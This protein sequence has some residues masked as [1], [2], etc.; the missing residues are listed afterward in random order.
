MIDRFSLSR[1]AFGAGLAGLGL[2]SMLPR[3]V[4]AQET[5]SVTT[6]L[7]T[8]D[9]PAD[10]QRVVCIDSRLDLEPAVALGLNVIG[11]AYGE[12][13]PW[14]PAQP[15]WA[16]VG[17]IPDL[18]QVLAL[19]PDLII[20]TDVGDHDSEY[21]PINRL[22]DVAPVLP[23][24]YTQ[25]WKEI[26]A[27]IGAWTG[28]DGAA[29]TVLA[30]Y[31]ALI[32]D[33]KL[34]RA[35]QIGSKTIAVVQ[36]WSDGTVFLQAEMSLLQ[37]QVMADLGS[38]TIPPVEGNIIAA[39]NFATVFGDV[40]AILYVNHGEGVVEQFATDPIWNR[41]P[42]IAAGKTL[43]PLGNTNYGGVYTATQIARFLDELYGL[44]A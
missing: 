11:H 5:R 39:E 1:R 26:L 7:G 10:P 43:A 12:P 23:P 2:T 20:C 25:P 19:D 33:I 6:V 22:K 35:D 9:I 32:A 4:F 15:N 24:A 42:A 16:F 21:W 36:P 27:Q 41:L 3:S 17:E 18:E 37:P 40:D 28:R 13:E 31:D 14:V 44:L 34:R 38:R 8:Y 30:E 29:D